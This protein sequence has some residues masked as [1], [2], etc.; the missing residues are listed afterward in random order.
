MYSSTF[1][2]T[3][4]T[5]GRTQIGDRIAKPSAR[6]VL[7]A[8]LQLFL[9]A[10]TAL[11]ACQASGNS[12]A[13][14]IQSCRIGT[15]LS[16]ISII[17]VLICNRGVA[18]PGAIIMYAF[19]AFQFGVPMIL[20]FDPSYTDFVLSNLGPAVLNKSSW[21]TVVCIQCF[22]LGSM[23]ASY[24]G[25]K[26]PHTDQK[27]HHFVDFA[28]GNEK[29]V[30]NTSLM[31][32]I[33]FGAIAYLYMLWFA[34]LSFSA[35][36]SYARDV[37]STN[38][39]R[40][41]ARGLF[42]PSGFMFLVFSDSKTA[43]KYVFALLVLYGLI[44]TASG[45]RTESMTLLVALAYYY[46]EMGFGFSGATGSKLLMV[47]ALVVILLL[48]PVVAQHR[49]GNAFTID[50]IGG[51]V[52]DVFAETGYN[53]YSICFQTTF[54]NGLHYGFSYLLSL[55]AMIPSS[56][57]PPSITA[58]F[59][60][61][62]PSNWIDDVMSSNFAWATFGQGYSMIAESSYNFGDFGYI[63]IG[64][65]GFAIQRLIQVP[66]SG[67]VKFSKYLSLVLLWSFITI[68]RRG[69]EFAVNS[70]E[71]DI[72]FMVLIMWLSAN[73]SKNRVKSSSRRTF[74]RGE[75]E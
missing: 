58:F 37:I 9:F 73:F 48:L 68:P 20:A 45:D 59:T 12:Y 49:I 56:L 63:V 1:E 7:S 23:I 51:L 13:D 62:L 46:G 70:L 52:E 11:Y 40:N 33:I 65:F 17:L 29:R 3:D 4:T 24:F 2:T 66:L 6:Y 30:A 43:R 67:N 14:F 25:A 8:L 50:S 19:V 60:S 27:P 41:M 28:L 47:L 22:A 31:I 38:A 39:V 57:M 15:A 75:T 35:G 54:S 10:M 36:I 5:A 42:V 69:F 61:N 16:L 44:G 53:F 55:L 32:F 64:L 74:S 71:Y 21:Y 26:K 34:A 72:L 18:K